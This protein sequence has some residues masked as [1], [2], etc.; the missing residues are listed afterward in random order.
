MDRCIVILSSLLVT[1]HIFCQQSI[2][3][4]TDTSLTKVFNQAEIQ[5][6]ESIIRYADNMVLNRTDKT[7]TTEAYH[8]FLEEIALFYDAISHTSEYT[9]AFEENT[10][11]TFLESL[12]TSV[13]DA[14]WIFETEME[15]I[16]Y[17]DT[18]Y[19]NLKNF[20]TLR[21]KAFSK[22]MD[23]L[24]VIGKDDPY[25]KSQQQLM[26]IVGNLSAGSVYEFAK[27]HRNFDFTI[28]KNRLWAAIYLI[29]REESYYKKLDRY[30]KK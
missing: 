14:V 23:Y 20:K 17:K 30:L 11:Y 18:V 13:F 5:G 26:E 24:K 6:L 29:N 9:M 16:F 21:L 28:P 2:D 25:F 22:Y 8:N 3:I 12:D 7:D 19:R 27:N 10:K 4:S 15:R 1:S